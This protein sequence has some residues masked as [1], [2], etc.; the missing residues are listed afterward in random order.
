[1][2]SITSTISRPTTPAAM[3]LLSAV[4]L[5]LTACGPS[6]AETGADVED[7]QEGE[8]VETTDPAD[9]PAEEMA[10]GPYVEPYDTDF[11]DE[12][13]TYVGEEVTLT[14]DVNE[15]ISSTAFTIAGTEDTT[16]SPVLV[17]GGEQTTNL[18]EGQAVEVIGTAQEAFD[19]LQVG[20]GLDDDLFA[21]HDGQP[22]I[23]ATEVSTGVP[24]E[25]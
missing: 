3:S 21:D 8:V 7:V 17:V 23:E 10:A 19:L 24:A 6:G 18:E 22:Y 9:D 11:C 20:E 13:T 14:G 2:G 12:A 1:M 16:V 15:I 25:G 5:G 4:T